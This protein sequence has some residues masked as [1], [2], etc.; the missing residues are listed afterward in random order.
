MIKI[1]E[2]DFDE[3]MNDLGDVLKGKE[4]RICKPY[5]QRA[6]SEEVELEHMEEGYVNAD[7]EGYGF[8]CLVYGDCHYI[9]DDENDLVMHIMEHY[10]EDGYG[11]DIVEV[12][13]GI[14]QQGFLAPIEDADK[15]VEEFKQKLDL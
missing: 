14:L 11:I 9:T 8:E 12:A 4:P 2:F 15:I 1:N 3:R 6:F 5:H 7:F 10:A 13:G